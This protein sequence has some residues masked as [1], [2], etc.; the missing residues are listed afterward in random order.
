MRIKYASWG[1]IKLSQVP[2]LLNSSLVFKS[3]TNISYLPYAL[4]LQ[5]FS[6]VFQRAESIERGRSSHGLRVQQHAPRGNREIKHSYAQLLRNLDLF[7]NVKLK[8]RRTAHPH[9]STPNGRLQQQIKNKGFVQ[10]QKLW[11]CSHEGNGQVLHKETLQRRRRRVNEVMTEG[12]TGEESF[13]MIPSSLILESLLPSR[14]FFSYLFSSSSVSILPATSILSILPYL[15]CA[16][17]VSLLALSLSFEG[18][19]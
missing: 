1:E 13:F 6:S 19:K 17:C 12:E 3:L 7:R 11:I 16:S 2:L 14:Q 10:R 15:F 18:L 4:N 5:N 8:T 9:W